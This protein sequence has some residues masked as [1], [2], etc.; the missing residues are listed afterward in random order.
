MR[1]T[2]TNNGSSGIVDRSHLPIKLKCAGAPDSC[3]AAARKEAAAVM[4]VL[5]PAML[6]RW[7]AVQIFSPRRPK[8]VLE[9][10][11]LDDARSMKTAVVVVRRAPSMNPSR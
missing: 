10:E 7:S 2:V 1:G 3:A 6:E 9:E 11:R 8:N 5:L 4:V